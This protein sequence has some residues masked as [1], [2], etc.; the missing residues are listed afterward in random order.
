MCKLKNKRLLVLGGNSWADAIRKYTKDNGIIMIA[1]GNNPNTQLFELADECYDINTT[2]SEKMKELIPSKQI[3]GVYLG[4]NEP[5]IAKACEYVN[6]LHLPCYCTKIQW[7][8]LQNKSIFKQCCINAGLPVVPQYY[9]VENDCSLDNNVFPVIT[10][11]V[12]GCGSNGFSVCKNNDELKM[13]YEKAKENSLSGQVLIEKY[14]SNQGHVVFY[15]VSDGKMVF[16]GLSD[17]YPVRFEKQ[18]SY[19][20]GIFIYNSKYVEQFRLKFEDK[21]QNMISNLNIKEGTF[22]IEVFHDKDEYFFNEAGFRYGGSVSIYPVDYL[23]GIN[24]VASDIYF[25]LTGESKI[26]GHD[27]L[28]AKSVI[29]H[30]Y[31]AIYPVYVKPGTITSIKGIDELKENSNILQVLQAKSIYSVVADSG[32]FGQAAV[33]VH[34]GFDNY[35][36]LPVLINQIHSRLFIYNEVGHSMI[37]RMLNVDDILQK[38]KLYKVKEKAL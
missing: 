14:V 12:D 19:V 29:K 25:A 21:I 36:E 1:A 23:Y 32:S 9:I 2:D 24:Q 6:E 18:G 20:G 5:V 8:C 33:L 22:W 4:G 17:K 13:G 10:K 16:S 15:T 38:C 27:S 34:F 28:F 11:P 35:E 30:R 37:T 26:Y 7:E 31:Y 3:D